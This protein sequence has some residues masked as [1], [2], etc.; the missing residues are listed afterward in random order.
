MLMHLHMP[1]LPLWII[2]QAHATI[3]QSHTN[4]V[5]SESCR[6]GMLHRLHATAS[7]EEARTPT[8][9]GQC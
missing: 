3:F 2:V 7:M 4:E 8:F 5:D 6:T 9:P 1:M